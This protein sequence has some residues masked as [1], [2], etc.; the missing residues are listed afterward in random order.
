MKVHGTEVLRQGSGTIAAGSCSDRMQTTSIESI[1]VLVE[2]IESRD[3][4]I[5]GHSLHVA[6]LAV[7]LAAHLDF[8]QRQ[9]LLMEFAGLLHDVGK[10]AIPKLILNKTIPLS[11]QEWAIIKKHSL[12]G[13]KILEPIH[14]LKPIQTWILYHHERW[15]GTGYPRGIRKQDIPLQSRIL[16]VCDTFSAMIS[17]RPYR[18][19]LSMGKALQEV[20]TVSGSQLDPDIARLFLR[21]IKRPFQRVVP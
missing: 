17:D 15:D 11:E 16:S 2:T 10:I 6:E 14:N 1:R 7:Q 13:A 21:I 19:A 3:P 9:V 20:K 12:L 18:R 5:K 4:Y 8:T